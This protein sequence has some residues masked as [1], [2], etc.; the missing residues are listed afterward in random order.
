MSLF[1]PFYNL[2]KI[3]LKIL[4]DYI[5]EYLNNNFITWL[6]ASAGTLILFIK[7]NK[8]L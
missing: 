8:L 6:K 3:E 4:Q 7:K 1:R 5:K 2:L